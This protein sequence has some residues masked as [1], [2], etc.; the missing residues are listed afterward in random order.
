MFQLRKTGVLNWAMAFFAGWCLIAFLQKTGSAQE[1]P[2]APAAKTEAK[3]TS[4]QSGDDIFIGD[5]EMNGDA[6]SKTADSPRPI[7][8][9]IEE[10]KTSD[11]AEAPASGPEMLKDNKMEA[12]P[13]LSG[14]SA[15]EK[16]GAD[17]QQGQ[18]TTDGIEARR[19]W[20]EAV[21]RGNGGDYVSKCGVAEQE[22]R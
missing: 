3:K 8:F 19:A 13:P 16:V 9:Y 14:Q 5:I 22:H 4:W 15:S 10:P 12:A 7:Q 17:G 18:K 1:G 21:R 6:K 11:A 2:D 20:E